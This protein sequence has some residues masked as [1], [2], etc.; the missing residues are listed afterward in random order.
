LVDEDEQDGCR[1]DPIH[2]ELKDST[3][4]ANSATVSVAAATLHLY[5]E[6]GRKIVVFQPTGTAI[7]ASD[8]GGGG[9]DVVEEVVQEARGEM[10]AS[11]SSFKTAYGHGTVDPSQLY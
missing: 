4:K 10:L 7:D 1:F 8:V 6:I 9:R 3:I 2:P 5:V 11:L